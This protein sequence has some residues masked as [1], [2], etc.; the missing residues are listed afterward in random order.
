MKVK[1]YNQEGK[2]VGSQE[3]SEKVFGVKLDEGVV[4]QVAVAM[5]ANRRQVLAHAKDRSEVRGGGK[6]PWKQ[7][8]TGRARHG[9]IRSPLWVGGGVTFGPTRDRNFKK[10]INEKTRRKAIFMCLSDRVK[11]N[12]LVLL[13]KIVIDKFGTK[14][15]IDMIEGMRSVFC[16]DEVNKVVNKTDKVDKKNEN[17]KEK[18]IKIKP[19]KILM[20]IDKKNE[21][22]QRSCRNIPWIS[23]A[24]AQDANVLSILSNEFILASVDGVKRIEEVFVKK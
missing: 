16:K 11:N 8:G 18:K 1:I 2:E 10:K 13:D 17:K 24:R 3:L 5:F 14:R 9:S 7:K 15:I 4:H 20:L 19:K 21:K 23:C 6:K 22:I 12:K